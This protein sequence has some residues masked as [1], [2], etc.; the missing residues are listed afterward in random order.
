M[1]N[2]GCRVPE[3]SSSDSCSRRRNELEMRAFDSTSI[4]LATIGTMFQ[5]GKSAKTESIRGELAKHCDG[6]CSSR[7]IL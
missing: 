1:N 5:R 4:C 2:R 6:K 7:P 3:Q